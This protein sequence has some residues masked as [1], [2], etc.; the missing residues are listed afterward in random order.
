MGTS[1]KSWSWKIPPRGDQGMSKLTSLKYKI[2][3]RSLKKKK[4]NTPYQ[5]RYEF[6]NEKISP[7]FFCIFMRRDK[8]RGSI[9]VFYHRYECSRSLIS[10]QLFYG[11]RGSWVT[12]AF[13]DRPGGLFGPFIS[14]A[15]EFCVRVLAFPFDRG[16]ASRAQ[17]VLFR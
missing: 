13:D 11:S 14:S 7:L 4:K 5:L 15:A 16:H 1:Q 3:Q 17:S 12:G 10:T 9:R 6:T 8:S 2:L